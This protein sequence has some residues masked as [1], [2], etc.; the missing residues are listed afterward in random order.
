MTASD[1]GREAVNE[2]PGGTVRL[3]DGQGNQDEA[4]T[5]GNYYFHRAPA[6]LRA[7]RPNDAAVDANLSPSP[8]VDRHPLEEIRSPHAAGGGVASRRSPPA[9]PAATGRG[10]SSGNT[11][12]SG[13]GFLMRRSAR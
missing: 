5:G 11:T 10:P 6:G 8:E 4:K 12:T 13:G 7:P 9:R 2:I 3:S 1:R